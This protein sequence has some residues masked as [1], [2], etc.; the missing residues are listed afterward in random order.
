LRLP[1]VGVGLFY[2]EGYFR[3]KIS[4]EGRQEEGNPVADPAALPLAAALG[5]EGLPLEIAIELPGRRVLAAVRIARVGRTPLVLLDA[6]VEGNSAADRAITRRLYGGDVETRLQQEILLGV[7]GLRALDA[8]GWRPTVRHL[9]EGHAAFATLEKIRQL[10]VEEGRPFADARRLA[11]AGNVFTTHTPVPAG[12]DLFPR[13]L[14]DRYFGSLAEELGIGTD[15][16][17]GL[18]REIADPERNLFS[19][20]ALALRLSGK[21]NAVSK[22][23]ARVSRGLW[24]KMTPDTPVEEVPIVPITNG[25]HHDTWTDPDMR[26]EDPRRP[27]AAEIWRRHQ[28]LRRR[29]VARCREIVGADVLDPE[30]LTIGFARRFATYKR[31]PLVFTDADRLA[32]LIHAEGRPLQLVFAGKAHPHDQPGKEFVHRIVSYSGEDRFRGSVVFLPDYDVDVA[33][34]L[35]SGC[36]VWLNNPERPL[37]ASG[38]SGM[39]AG[40]NGVLNLS[41]LDGWWDEAPREE[42]GF[43]FGLAQDHPPADVMAQALYTVLEN[44]VI[45]LFWARDAEGVPRGW[46]EKMRNAIDRIGTLFSTDRMIR[47]YLDLAWVPAARQSQRQNGSSPKSSPSDK[48][49]PELAG[50]E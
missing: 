23:H 7:G 49:D 30:A 15:E 31:A 25:V 27:D 17:Y 26:F 24:Q 48:P 50:K 3:Q 14:I 45:P 19:M 13:E 29:L 36:D 2:R 22:L 32:G 44:E 18:G 34:L 38:T 10:V 40:M 35:V 8:L 37:E 5:A 43:S 47:E 46:V 1:L 21:T 6:D 28:G 9:N 11:A 33:R 4:E 12:I 39:K 20:A 16:L 42:T 41:A